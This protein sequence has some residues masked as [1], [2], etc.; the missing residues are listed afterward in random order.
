MKLK[1]FTIIDLNASSTK[2]KQHFHGIS[3]TTMQF[4]TATNPGITQEIS[5]NFDAFSNTQRLNLPQD[6]ICLNDIP[7]DC[8][9]SLYY[10]VCTINTEYMTTSSNDNLGRDNEFAW[11]ESVSQANRHNCLPWSKFHSVN[12]EFKQSK[13]IDINAMMPLI[14]EKVSSIKSQY[15]CMK[16]I[17]DT[18]GFLYP[19]QIP[20]DV[21]DKP[22]FAFRKKY[23]YAIHQI[24]VQDCIF[25]C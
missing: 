18:I 16:I 10:P 5:Y 20:V 15:H 4:P 21:S 22:V 1:L 7:F 11:L 3:M 17:R 9:S 23:S 19:N 6:Y 24:L 14:N 13:P 12:S 2:I 25:V 8:S